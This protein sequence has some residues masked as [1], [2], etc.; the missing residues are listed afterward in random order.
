MKNANLYVN[1]KTYSN[2]IFGMFISKLILILTITER[3]K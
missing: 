2:K 1:Q 3:L